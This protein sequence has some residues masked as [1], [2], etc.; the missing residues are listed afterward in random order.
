[1]RESIV[2]VQMLKHTP[3]WVF[4]LFVGLA[5]LG[6]L[7]S[8]ARFVSRKRLAVL[9]LAML[10]LSFLGVWSSFGPDPIASGSWTVALLAAIAVG[11]AL[12]PPRNVAYSPEARLFAVPGSWVPLALMMCIFFTKYAVAVMRAVTASASNSIALTVVTCTV[13][14]LC[15]GIFFARALRV[16]R[17]ARQ[18]RP[19]LPVGASA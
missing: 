8:R 14:G 1:L 15:S 9:P 10:G 4:G 7:Q 13:C 2:L 3:W 17:I 12:P 19:A 16:A 6:Y 18:P 5:Y 11:L